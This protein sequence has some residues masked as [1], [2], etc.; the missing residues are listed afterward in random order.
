MK[1][2]TM[3]MESPNQWINYADGNL[4]IK[5]MDMT[6]KETHISSLG[7][8]KTFEA[9]LLKE[10]TVLN[11]YVSVLSTIAGNIH[12]SDFILRMIFKVSLP[13]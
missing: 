3:I 4:I 12:A 1:P 11:I 7:N 5:A 10:Y 13:W 2:F 9:C 6:S 8:S